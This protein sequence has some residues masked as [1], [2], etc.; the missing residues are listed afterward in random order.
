MPLSWQID[1]IKNYQDLCWIPTDEIG[2]DGEPRVRLNPVTETLIFM[3]MAVRLGS[4]T[5]AN[6]DDFFAR[7]KIIEKLDGPMMTDSHGT[8]RCFTVEDIHDHVGLVCN[9]TSES[10]TKFLGILRD[11]HKARKRQYRAAIKQ[12]EKDSAVTA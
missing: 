1:Q 11:E 3:T 8:G 12:A 4:I 6:A 10:V 9:V 2:E 5:E 7:V